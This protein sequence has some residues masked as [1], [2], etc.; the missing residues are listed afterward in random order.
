MFGPEYLVFILQ[1][2]RT[3]VNWVGAD[4]SVHWVEGGQSRDPTVRGLT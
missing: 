2:L 1:S 3:L 4:W